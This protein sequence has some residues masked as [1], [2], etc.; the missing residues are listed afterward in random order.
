MPEKGISLA[1]FFGRKTRNRR[2]KVEE[3]KRLTKRQHEVLSLMA[4]G[5]SDR[6][7]ADA[8]FVS[9]RTVHFHLYKAY[10]KLGVSNRVQA[11]RQAIALGLIVV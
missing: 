6:E 1:S 10:G 5:K 11:F 2:M 7:I 3:T 4:E 8:L 9:P